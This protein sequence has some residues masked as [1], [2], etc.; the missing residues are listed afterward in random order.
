VEEVVQRKPL[1]RLGTSGQGNAGGRGF[2][3]NATYDNGGGGGGAGAVGAN[4]TT[5]QEC[6][7]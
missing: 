6:C 7:W 3:D 5:G 4:G 2:T 1:V